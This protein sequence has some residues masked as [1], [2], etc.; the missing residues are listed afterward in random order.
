MIPH[1]S[2]HPMFVRSRGRAKTRK[3]HWGLRQGVCDDMRYDNRQRARVVFDRRNSRRR[4]SR[5]SVP[6]MKEAP[7]RCA[8]G[9]GATAVLAPRLAVGH[10]VPSISRHGRVRECVSLPNHNADGGAAVRSLRQIIGRRQC[11]RR[12][13]AELFRKA[14][15][16]ARG[17][18]VG[19]AFV[20]KR[21]S[22]YVFRRSARWATW[23]SATALAARPSSDGLAQ[24][25]KNARRS[26]RAIRSRGFLKLAT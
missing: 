26:A 7:P 13:R 9:N 22:A 4:Q 20:D 21:C 3:S 6:R 15:G 10:Q 1:V 11:L 24:I 2:T 25:V 12:L 23:P 8:F 5:D 17:R 14:L 16:T 18:P 19:K